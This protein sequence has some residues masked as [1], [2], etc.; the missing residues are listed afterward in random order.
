MADKTDRLLKALESIAD[1]LSC[2]DSI[3]DS[4]ESLAGS[5]YELNEKLDA[6]TGQMES[7]SSNVEPRTF[8]RTCDI[9]RE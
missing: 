8:I 1:S 4:L 5:A 6:M 9:G 3:S 2:L 7:Y